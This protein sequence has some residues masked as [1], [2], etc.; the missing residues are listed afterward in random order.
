MSVQ[1]GYF[2]FPIQPGQ[3]N[4]LSGSMGE[5]RSNHFHGGLDIKTGGR[6]GLP[7]HAAAEGYISRISIS[8]SGYGKRIA[9]SH[10]NG[11][12][13]QYGHLDH[14]SK[15]LEDYVTDV[16]YRNKSF[17]IEIFP[18]KGQFNLNKGEIFAY[19]GNSGSSGGPHLHFEVR[20]SMDNVYNPLQF[21]F[22]EIVDRVAPA[23]YRISLNP[24]GPNSFVDGRHEKKIYRLGTFKGKYT[25]NKKIT[26]IGDLGLSIKAYDRM[27]GT[28]NKYG[29]Q[30]I[31]VW[32]DGERVFSQNIDYYPI[33]LNR[34]INLH[35]DYNEYYNR[36]SWYHK[37]YVSNGNQLP[38]YQFKDRRGILKIDDGKTHEIQ[39]FIKDSY[40]NTSVL[41]F[42]IHGEHANNETQNSEYDSLSK[43]KINHELHGS[44]L[45]LK[46]KNVH[47]EAP[48]FIHSLYKTRK[49]KK[50]ISS[51]NSG[52]YFYNLNEGIP[53][54]LTIMDSTFTL[55]YQYMIQPDRKTIYYNDP[56]KVTFNKEAVTDTLF[57]SHE[58]KDS[59]LSLHS[60][61]IP[62]SDHIQIEWKVANKKL[63][64]STQVYLKG[65]KSLSY[66]GKSWNNGSIKFSTRQFGTFVLANDSIP[67]RIRMIY[68]TGE[69]MK[70]RVSDD[71]S[72]L[73][74][75]NFFVNGEWVLM[76]YD[77]KYNLLTSKV[78]DGMNLRGEC[79]IELSDRAG[80]V[81]EIDL[82]L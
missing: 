46:I 79:K 73:D 22:D 72:G 74:Q 27:N 8:P 30:E 31:Q 52:I 44:L 21:G 13:T 17:S 48:L 65:W 1:K 25:V 36:G 70:F 49:I 40:Q 5:L 24:I 19:S 69:V 38:F 55:P 34:H 39:V 42:K 82:E 75:Y 61:L 11:Y 63:H 41:E 37:C 43:I 18:E 33:S 16:Q 56:I 60:P 15:E 4:Y 64:N 3:R 59:I 47:D 57:L 71:L 10:P 45:E 50:S 78:R 58:I 6:I 62:L 35:V 66:L 20:D 32:M 29:V 9:I 26:A 12:V 2:E 81:K 80:N 14:F 23:V 68:N 51:G 28:Y 54:S 77:A 76:E 7:V 67:P 53:D